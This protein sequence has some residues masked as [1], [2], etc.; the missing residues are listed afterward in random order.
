MNQDHITK[1]VKALSPNA[2][3]TFHGTDL[4]TL[5]ID[6]GAERPTDKAIADKIT[7]IE[8]SEL[9]EKQA[10]AEQKAGL[11]ERLGIT[12]EEAQLLLS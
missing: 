2:E 11:L 6:N 5:V 10:K 9:A 1:A 3:F 4:S 7:E 12:A 8:N